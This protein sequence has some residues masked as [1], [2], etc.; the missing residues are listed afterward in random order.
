MDLMSEGGGPRVLIVSDEP[1]EFLV[2]CAGR[3]AHIDYTVCSDPDDIPAALSTVSPS[4]VFVAPGGG[5]RKAALR[6]VVDFPDRK[7]VV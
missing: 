4:V 2:P 1:D 6:Q 3:M 5:M 7:S